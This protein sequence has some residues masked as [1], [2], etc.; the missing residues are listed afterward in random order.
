MTPQQTLSRLL[1]EGVPLF[2]NSVGAVPNDKLDWVPTEGARTARQL[3]T[4]VV[5]MPAYT[6]LALVQRQV[7]EYGEFSERYKAMSVPELLRQL[8]VNTQ[9]LS[10]AINAFPESEFDKTLTAPWGTWTYFQTMSY[11]YWNL[12]WHTG[13]INYIQTLYGDQTHY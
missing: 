3:I 7:P 11:P 4:E 1:T 9:Q 12:M 10:E 13:Q 2:L 5:M 8:T 6:A